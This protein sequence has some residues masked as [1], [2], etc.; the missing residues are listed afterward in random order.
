MERSWRA[1]AGDWPGP[2]SRRHGRAKR[3]LLSP[4]FT[5]MGISGVYAPWTGEAHINGQVPAARLGQVLGHEKA[6]QR[7][8]AP[9]DEA[10]F[11]GTLAAARADDPLARYAGLLFAQR[12]ILRAL[13]RADGERA[14]PLIR[15]RHPGVQRDVDD[16]VAFWTRHRGRVR[17]WARATNDLYLRGHRIP[18]GRLSYGR[19]VELLVRWVRRGESIDRP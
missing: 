13:Q 10:N 3:P 8:V 6:H 14:M 1:L 19:S 4:L 17:N 7:G 5:R 16:I 9:E 11:L 15:A 18:D 12:Q 2:A